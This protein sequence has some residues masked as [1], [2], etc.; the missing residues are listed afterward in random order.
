MAGTNIIQILSDEI[1]NVTRWKTA[2]RISKIETGLWTIEWE[3]LISLWK[4]SSYE[5]P[6]DDGHWVD[7][8]SR[9]KVGFFIFTKPVLCELRDWILHEFSEKIWHGMHHLVHLFKLKFK[10][11][12]NDNISIFSKNLDK[13][14]THFFLN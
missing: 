7:C 13:N 6:I 12:V 11:H 10:L 9:Q 14:E 2:A 1:E 4:R 8:E 5:C 3:S